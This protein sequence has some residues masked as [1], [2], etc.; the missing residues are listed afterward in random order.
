MKALEPQSWLFKC[1]GK[2]Y[3]ELTPLTQLV[4]TKNSSVHVH[5]HLIGPTVCRIPNNDPRIQTGILKSL[6]L[7]ILL[8]I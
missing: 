1:T 7:S 3:K 2:I 5:H 8:G 4:Q 6:H